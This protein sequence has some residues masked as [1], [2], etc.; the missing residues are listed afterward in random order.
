MRKNPYNKDL[1]DHLPLVMQGPSKTTFLIENEAQKM[2]TEKTFVIPKKTYFV[3]KKAFVMLSPPFLNFDGT[4]NPEEVRNIEMGQ[5]EVT[6]GLFKA[7]M[8]WNN[9]EHK[10]GTR[11][12]EGITWFD[13]IAFCNKLSHILGFHPYYEMSNIEKDYLYTDQNI[14]KASVTINTP[15]PF[16]VLGEGFR[17]PTEEE[18]TLFATA[19]A[20]GQGKRDVCPLFE[21]ICDYGWFH[22]NSDFMTHPVAE[23]KPNKW[24]L[25]DMLGNVREFGWGE[26]AHEDLGYKIAF[27]C[28]YR[29]TSAHWKQLAITEQAGNHPYKHIGFRICRNIK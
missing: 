11:P 15:H 20:S 22:S 7:V 24:D 10:T 8:G 26:T 6:Q 1:K 28:S 5:T 2:S 13:A 18:W 23:K 14:S 3:K 17:L 21:D 9:S 12:V 4:L 19:G 16:L 25:Y 29:D 27:G